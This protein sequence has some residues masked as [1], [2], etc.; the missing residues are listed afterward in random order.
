MAED[1]PEMIQFV[2]IHKDFFVKHSCVS[3]YLEKL[4]MDLIF[5]MNL[6]HSVL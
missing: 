5:H 3:T 2:K 1:R 6:K 4:K